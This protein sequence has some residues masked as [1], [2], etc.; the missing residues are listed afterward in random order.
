MAALVA[1]K[2]YFIARLNADYQ[3]VWFG[4][5]SDGTPCDVYEMTYAEVVNRMYELLYLKHQKRW[6]DPSLCEAF[7][8]FLRRVEERFT[9]TGYNLSPSI[10]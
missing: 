2:D 1:R 10:V 7:G 6:I 5:K 8:D 9:S 3:K 4:K